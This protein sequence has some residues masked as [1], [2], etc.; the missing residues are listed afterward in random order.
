MKRVRTDIIENFVHGNKCEVIDY[1]FPLVFES[2]VHLKC[3]C[4]N[5]FSKSIKQINQLRWREAKISCGCIDKK[6]TNAN[7]DQALKTRNIQRLTNC[8]VK[9]FQPSVSLVTWKCTQCS[10]EWSSRADS[11]INKKTGCPQCAGNFAYTIETLNNKLALQ[12][13]TDLLAKDIINGF[14]NKTK[15]KNRHGVFEC[16]TCKANW[17]A[18]IHNVLKFG[19]GC[20]TCNNNVGT[21]I[22]FEDEVFH[23]KLEF[24]F[25]KQFKD[26]AKKY[27]LVRQQRYTSNRRL[28]C[29]YYIPELQL[30]IEVTGSYLMKTKKYASTIEEKRR[31]VEERNERFVALS[32]FVEINNFLETL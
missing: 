32:S 25:W 14:Q 12:G 29:D 15:K 10:L 11:I 23:S 1:E 16:T 4:G 19:Y 9:G 2:Q 24:Y 3:T 27:T 5:L 22:V 26:R 18:D 30:W 6:W 31:I 13:R 17:I 7:I 20:P 28:T 21:K 8:D